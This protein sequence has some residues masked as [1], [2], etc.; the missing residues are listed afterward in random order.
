MSYSTQVSVDCVAQAPPILSSHMAMLYV[1]KV[2]VRERDRERAEDQH[3]LFSIEYG[4]G[5]SDGAARNQMNDRARYAHIVDS[6]SRPLFT[7]STPNPHAV[8]E[9]FRSLLAPIAREI[10]LQMFKVVT[11]AREEDLMRIIGEIFFYSPELGT[12]IER[13]G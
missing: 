13:R 2:A 6:V 1:S 4:P 9:R 5:L 3:A 8:M 11:G 10:E 7:I 12:V